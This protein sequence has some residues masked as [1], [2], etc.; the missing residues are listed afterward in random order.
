[1]IHLHV[2]RTIAAPQEE[3]FDWLADPVNLA[4][5]PLILRAG[6][7]AGALGPRVGAVR[8]ATAVAMWLREEITAF[9]RPR[10]YSYRIIRSFPAMNHDG[11]SLT[12]TPTVGGTHVVWVSDLAYPTRAGGRVT[13]LITAPLLRSGFSGILAGCAKALER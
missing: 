10:G 2:Q 12:F 5:T 6:W 4:A 1:M 9:D 7:T 11:G 13:E 8:Q 3:V